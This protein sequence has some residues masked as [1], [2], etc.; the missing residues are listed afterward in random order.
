VKVCG[1]TIVRN[2]V[3]F[4][5]P[6]VESI[7]SVIDICDEFV[8]AV[9]NSDDD[10]LQL[11]QNIQSPKIRI[12]ETVW[13]DTLR[14]GG[15]V[16]AVETNKA[17]DSIGSE[18]DWCLYLQA[19]EVVHEKHHSVIVEAMKNFAHNTKV[20]GL[21][22][23]Y[24]HF[25]GTYDYVGDSKRWYRKEVRVVRNDK[26]IRS[27][28]DAQGFQKDGRPLRVKEIEAYI[29][30][31]GWVK[32]PDKQQEKQKHFNKLWHDD[33]WVNDN[34]ADV[35]EFDYSQ[36]D[37]LQRFQETHP[38][39]MKERIERLNYHVNIDSSQKKFKNTWKRFIY[40]LEK[41]T[42]YRVGEY[43]NYKKI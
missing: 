38:L 37:S 42:G 6:I 11:I 32:P 41:K 29:H 3:K 10:T 43:K 8:V 4:D 12:I 17:M 40:W 5:Y 14:E 28:R 30:H 19:D 24:L 13:D 25:Y 15:R 21:L 23:K 2:A 31:Y 18:F 7:L 35:L 34:I 16:L 39:I 36:F 22:F 20:E 1:F 26:D 9:G 27:F 33:N